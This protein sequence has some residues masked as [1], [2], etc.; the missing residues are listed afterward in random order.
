MISFY[1][2]SGSGLPVYLQLVRQV[3]HAVRLGRLEPGD[4]LP[5]V[6]DVVAS[7]A[8]NPNTVV[9]AY[10]DLEARR[11]VD[12]RQGLGTFVAAGPGSRPT[13]DDAGLR[14]TLGRWVTEAAAAGLGREDVAALFESVVRETFVEGVA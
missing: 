11:L 10:R 6:R 7:L 8:I 14:R 5:S 1:L 12:R 4:Q 9:K 13:A 3:E 2:D